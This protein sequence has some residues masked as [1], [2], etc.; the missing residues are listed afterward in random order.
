VIA[1]GG[2][3]WVRVCAQVYNDAEDVAALAQALEEAPR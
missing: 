1:R 3:L 2:R